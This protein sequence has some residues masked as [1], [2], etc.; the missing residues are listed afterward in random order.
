MGFG[1]HS[2]W[3]MWE[4]TGIVGVVLPCSFGWRVM[5]S[6]GQRQFGIHPS[7]GGIQLND[8]S[9]SPT[10]P[11]RKGEATS[12]GLSHGEVGRRFGIDRRTVKQMLSYSAP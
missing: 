7:R 9:D 3:K 12:E 1:M 4:C 5:S 8:L 11:D 6:P 10:P 2:K